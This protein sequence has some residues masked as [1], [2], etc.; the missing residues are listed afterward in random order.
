MEHSFRIEYMICQQQSL[1]PTSK[2]KCE[3]NESVTSHP[4]RST[5]GL[6]PTSLIFPLIFASSWTEQVLV[7]RPTGTRQRRE[8][9]DAYPHTFVYS[10]SSY[11]LAPLPPPTIYLYQESRPWKERESTSVRPLSFS[12][13]SLLSM[14]FA[15]IFFLTLPPTPFSLSSSSWL[16]YHPLDLSD[17]IMVL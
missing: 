2:I 16:L 4:L 11:C 12:N 14:A 6:R 10:I 13:L 5:P 7:A 8:E 3:A 17:L 9:Y 1:R 15:V